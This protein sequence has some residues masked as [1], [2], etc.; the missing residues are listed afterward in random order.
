ML[1]STGLTGALFLKIANVE[2]N[3]MKLKKLVAFRYTPMTTLVLIGASLFLAGI[4]FDS[5]TPFK[6]STASADSRLGIL[7]QAAPELNL[8]TWIDGNGK[9]IE[10]VRLS[11][12]HGKVVYLYFFQDW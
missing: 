5:S 3:L 4:I 2:V 7:G 12:Y 9:K 11:D 10:S 1:K 8:S 6:I